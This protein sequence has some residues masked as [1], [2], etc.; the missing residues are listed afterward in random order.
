M[1]LDAGSM[2]ARPESVEHGQKL[3]PLR[4]CSLRLLLI[5][6]TLLYASHPEFD[7]TSDTPFFNSN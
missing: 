4:S 6:F 1:P 5:L 2:I 3:V 7:D